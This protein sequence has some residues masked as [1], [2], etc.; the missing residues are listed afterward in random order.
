MP[1]H[2]GVI[3]SFVGPGLNHCLVDF[4]GLEEEPISFAV[5]H[6]HDQDGFYWGLI[7]PTEDEWKI[8]A[9]TGWWTDA[10]LA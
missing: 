5:G 10:P 4:F 7:D 9:A 2:P 3:N 8:A 6:D 1:R